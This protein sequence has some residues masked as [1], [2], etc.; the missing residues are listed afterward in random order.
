MKLDLPGTGFKQTLLPC[1]ALVEAALKT[2]YKFGVL[3]YI[4]TSCTILWF[5]C[6]LALCVCMCL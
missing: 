6:K 1:E 4:L 3:S 2:A 5:I